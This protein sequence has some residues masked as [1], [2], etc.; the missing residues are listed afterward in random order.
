VSPGAVWQARNFKNEKGEPMVYK[1][2][3]GTQFKISA[4][5]A[6]ERIDEIKSNLG[7][8]I[9][10]Q[11]VV[12]DARSSSSPLHKVFDWDDKRAAHQ[13]RLYLARVLMASIM[14][15]Y[16]DV[17]KPSEPARQIR[18]FVSLRDSGTKRDRTFY[19]LAQ[20]M[21]DEEKR[22]QLLRQALSEFK[23]WKD[24]YKQFQELSEIF[25][26]GNLVIGRLPRKFK[27]ESSL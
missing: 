4:Q 8:N 9:K 25:E 1:W 7:R 20:V 22:D 10:A 13:Q 17:T 21:S 6:G 26:S 18:S 11:D 15:I 19:P 5:T 2:K 24:R 12:E 27:K 23:S 14:T 3:K 16:V